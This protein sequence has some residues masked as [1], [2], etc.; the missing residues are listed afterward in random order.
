MV[1]FADN[2]P[3]YLTIRVT[4]PD[5]PVAEL[6][7]VEAWQARKGYPAL[8][9][10]GGPVFGVARER[11]QGGWEL[12]G[13]L[14]PMPQ[15]ARDDL[16]SIARGKAGEAEQAGDTEAA[17]RYRAV[18][19]RL[20]WEKVDEVELDGR[21]RVVRV[22]RFARTGPDGPEPPRSTDPADPR[23]RD[24]PAAPDPLDGFV[25]DPTTPSGMSEGILR[26]DL[27]RLLP[28]RVRFSDAIHQ[29][30]L[31]ARETHPGV[32]LLPPGFTVA[33]REDG[34]WTPTGY[35]DGPTP[36]RARDTLSLH[37]RVGE[38]VH[39]GLDAARR[40]DYAAA[41][42]R[43]EEGKHDEITVEGRLLRIIRVER[44]VRIG[45]DGPEGPRPSDPDPEDPVKLQDQKLRAQGV[46]LDDEDDETWELDD[47]TK[48][49]QRLFDAELV[50]RGIEPPG[51]PERRD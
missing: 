7:D 30:A 13:Y 14:E 41:A 17:A 45:P 15:S 20:D 9:S 37:L 50:R 38:P 31:A 16:G 4:A 6:A 40:A 21:Y 1:N 19:D 32:V 36:F 39:R 49:F 5:G 33:E 27:M 48:E 3:G 26:S 47:Q 12:H 23:E 18:V 29:D 2:A 43:L 51:A 46:N 35:P 44:V 24:L 42:D 34:R 25:I 28:G 22:E 11:E 10:A 8:S